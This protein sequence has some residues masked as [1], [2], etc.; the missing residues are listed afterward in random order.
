[1][2]KVLEKISSKLYKLDKFPSLRQGS[3]R[4]LEG[5]PKGGVGIILAMILLSSFHITF[6]QH[7]IGTNSTNANAVMQ[8]QSA[9][10]T[11]GLVIPYVTTANRPAP[12][13][14]TEGMVIYNVT[15]SALQ[16]CDG[17]AWLDINPTDIYDGDNDTKIQVEE[18]LDEDKIRFDTDGSERMIIDENGNVGIGN[19]SPTQS[20]HVTGNSK[21]S[22]YDMHT[23][24]ANYF[25]LNNPVSNSV[26]GTGAITLKVA[27]GNSRVSSYKISVVEAN[28]GKSADYWIGGMSHSSN[29]WLRGRAHA[30]GD[31]LMVKTV[32]LG[33]N[34]SNEYYIQI[35]EITDN[36]SQPVRVTVEKFQVIKNSGLF[37][38]DENDYLQN[39]AIS[40][41]TT[42]VLNTTNYTFTDLIPQNI[43]LNSGIYGGDGTAPSNVDV[44]MTNT[45]DFGDGTFFIDDSNDE[46]GIGTSS[47]TAKFHV[48]NDVSGSDSAFVITKQGLVGIGTTGPVAPLN[49][50]TNSFVVDAAI[51]DKGSANTA[52]FLRNTSTGYN[53]NNDGLAIGISGLGASLVNKENGQLSIGTNNEVNILVHTDGN[54]GIGSGVTAARFHVTNDV[55]GSDSA[56]VVHESGNTSIGSTGDVAKLEIQDA[57]ANIRF[58]GSTAISGMTI[59]DGEED[60]AITTQVAGGAINNPVGATIFLDH[61]SEEIGINTTNPSGVLHIHND[62]L[63]S[64]SAFVVTASS[65]VG[66]GTTN[67]LANLHLYNEFSSSGTALQVTNEPTGTNWLRVTPGD[68]SKIFLSRSGN[69]GHY[70]EISAGT[71]GFTFNAVSGTANHA[72]IFQNQSTESMRLDENGNLGI[73]T[74]SPEELLHIDANNDS[75]QIDNLS[76]GVFN[77]VLMH[78]P[79]TGKIVTGTV[80]GLA[81][82]L[83]TL[84]DADGDTK[85][86]VEE[87]ADEDKIRFDTD[88]TERMI[89]DETGNVG[90]GTTTPNVPL[91]I[92]SVNNPAGSDVLKVENSQAG[93]HSH[94]NVIGDDE[95]M[96]QLTSDGASKGLIYTDDSD[97]DLKIRAENGGHRFLTGGVELARIQNDGNVGIGTSAP[98]GKFHVHNDVTGADSAFIVSAK[99]QVGIGTTST[100]GSFL[101]VAN[102]TVGNTDALATFDGN[103]GG[104]WSFH[105]GGAVLENTRG[106]P[107]YLN[108]KSGTGQWF[109][110]TS[111]A[112]R[113]AINNNGNVGIG[114]TSADGQLHINSGADQGTPHVDADDL[115]IERQSGNSGLS[116]LSPNDKKQSIVFGDADDI[117]IGQLYYNHTDN[118]MSFMTNTNVAATISSSGNLGIGTSSPDEE[119]HIE[120]SVKMVDGNE[121]NGYIMVSDAN[122]TGA[123][124]DPTTITTAD[125]GDWTTSGN[126][127]YNSNSGNVGVG[128]T[129]ATEKFEVY[130]GNVLFGVD[131]AGL[132]TSKRYFRFNNSTADGDAALEIGTPNLT[133]GNFV[134]LLV[135]PTHTNAGN[136]MQGIKIDLPNRVFANRKSYGFF[137]QDTVG[138]HHNI[139]GVHVEVTRDGGLGNHDNYAGYFA[140]RTDNGKAYALYTSEGLNYFGD[141][142]GI[143]TTLPETE[144]DVAGSITVGPEIITSQDGNRNTKIEFGTNII[145]LKQS[146]TSTMRLHKP[147]GQ[148]EAVI[149][150]GSSD[151]DFR[152]ESDASTHAI[153][154][155]GSSGNVG[156][157]TSSPS[158]RFHV[159]SGTIKVS[160]EDTLI[161]VEPIANTST[162]LDIDVTGNSDMY[163]YD[164]K[165]SGTLRSQV[166][167][168]YGRLRFLANP[169]LAG[170]N[171]IFSGT[172]GS[173]A[174]Y[175]FEVEKHTNANGDV[176]RIKADGNVGIGYEDP[177]ARFH[178][179]NDVVG[180]DSAFVVTAGGNVG[181][182]TTAPAASLHVSTTDPT[183]ALMHRETNT[184]GSDIGSV[185]FS[186]LSSTSSR[187]NYAAIVSNIT[188]NTNG[189]H[190]GNLRFFTYENASLDEQMRITNVGNVGIGTSTVNSKLHVKATSGGLNS[191]IISE[192]SSASGYATTDLYNDQSE[193]SQFVLTGSSYTNNIFVPRMAAWYTN[194]SGGL[195]IVSGNAS[196]IIQFATGGSAA[197][198]E[199]MR[200]DANGNVGIGVTPAYQLEVGGAIMLEDAAAPTNAAGHSGIYSSGGEL[201]AF[202]ASG[203]ST[204][205]SPHNFSLFP[206]GPSEEMAWSFYS[207]RD[208]KAINVDMAKLVRTVEEISGKELLRIKNLNTGTL[209]T[210]EFQGL[211]FEELVKKVEQYRLD[212]KSMQ[213]QLDAQT[214]MIDALEERLNKIEKQ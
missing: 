6:A 44:T 113:M 153:F 69:S 104:V 179:T 42:S 182:G 43:A 127:I 102:N 48:H 90:I 23:D 139:E 26:S 122:G 66:I 143:G 46:V 195:G 178:V 163:I 75:I 88:G 72:M 89:I 111:S 35:G 78:D 64:D 197:A 4:A 160:G 207:Q 73:N 41:E 15:D 167:D 83:S 24:G 150:E 77:N 211:S 86:Q 38:V 125:D 213:D 99:G 138:S 146:G 59:G 118:S 193:L 53:A 92:Y 191:G 105:P 67:P 101:S 171:F 135:Q 97:D 168:D 65:N 58:Q 205:I 17:N 84:S 63:G 62:V 45:I 209:E 50:V 162:I 129:S 95:A 132:G 36:Y 60:L 5:C 12:G 148:S 1:M 158:E 14:T 30:I 189:A 149:N 80:S 165:R 54:V 137:M 175:L 204:I 202:D 79:A 180:S 52:F 55:T 27:I 152:Y 198:N 114:T 76:P 159:N 91:H 7:N 186:G 124:T 161:H 173:S 130:N 145:D 21:K 119:L 96:L 142:V 201:Q 117:D 190:D 120:G 151:V 108:A 123:W 19:S 199:R 110:Q 106:N 112:T 115:V 214:K 166:R 70:G 39:W 47:P 16:Y 10:S 29:Q 131:N 154:A 85:I 212:N 181:V 34:S 174:T 87:S 185:Y 116:F 210:S 176:F 2:V 8:I 28:T 128:T 74:A 121:S 177:L 32:R 141:S 93:R 11:Q 18:S 100:S 200:I 157:G 3:V 94:I 56:F 133:N 40:I 98:T 107:S 33:L 203:N 81:D 187:V 51:D 134:G 25:V 82:S 13:S 20:F 155:E 208:N 71:G 103:D 140:A 172:T 184:N 169:A 183:T 57:G 170:P 109:F 156:I 206:E 37:A 136:T 9:D 31:T 68:N 192:N 61:S 147:S 164:L 196:G 144:L 49:V 126:D 22:G 188:D 194:G